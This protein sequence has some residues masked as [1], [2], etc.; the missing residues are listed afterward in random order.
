MKQLLKR[1][2]AASQ[3]TLR[4]TPTAWAKLVY[5]R[6]AGPTEIGG[7]GISSAA[8]LLLIEDLCLVKQQCDAASV[9]FDDEAVADYFDRQVDQGRSPEQFARV[10]VHT[11]PG[12]SP[13]PSSTD[14]ETFSRVFGSCDWS[15]MLILARGGN[16][17]ARLQVGTEVR[18]AAEID[19][20]VDYQLPF[21]A[22]DQQAWQAEYE[23]LV[24]PIRPH[25]PE[26]NDASV[27]DEWSAFD[28]L[29][30][31]LAEGFSRAA[32]EGLPDWDPFCETSGHL[33]PTGETFYEH[34]RE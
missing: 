25:V 6:D 29:R 3:P 32:E 2:Q 14:E 27:L 11:H 7:F 28:H 13:S 30:W 17:Y 1:Q 20:T 16:S 10:W 18:L 5:L 26:P 34:A 33:E 19:V 21:D 4:L 8:D 22:S 31:E 23:A 9:V 24:E 12:N 15:V